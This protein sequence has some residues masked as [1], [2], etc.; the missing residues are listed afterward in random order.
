M[1][2]EHFFQENDCVATLATELPN[3]FAIQSVTPSKRNTDLPN[4]PSI[5][6]LFFRRILGKTQ[7]GSRR[8]TSTERMLVGISMGNEG[9]NPFNLEQKNSLS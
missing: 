2:L 1:K 6:L 4:V 5:S 3:G 7:R 8:G 9:K